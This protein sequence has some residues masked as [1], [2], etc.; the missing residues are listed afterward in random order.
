[1]L[2]AEL[3]HNVLRPI[4]RWLESLAVVR[5]SDERVVVRCGS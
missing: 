2:D 3:S 5:V 4:D 1:M